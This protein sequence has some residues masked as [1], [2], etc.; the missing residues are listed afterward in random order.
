MHARSRNKCMQGALSL[1]KIR[2]RN[3]A[4]QTAI[5][6]VTWSNLHV[7]LY[8]WLHVSGVDFKVIRYTEKRNTFFGFNFKIK[9][10]AAD[11]M[12]SPWRHRRLAVL[13]RIIAVRVGETER[14]QLMN[15]EGLLS[16]YLR[17]TSTSRQCSHLGLCQL[18]AWLV[19]HSWRLWKP[20][21]LQS[22]LQLLWP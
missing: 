2:Q 20:L 15:D 9:K 1:R 11:G 18:S 13:M 22:R 6:F 16:C 4:C 3:D 17:P 21:L 7:Q 10:S 8:T 19:G 5:C 14:I 12:T